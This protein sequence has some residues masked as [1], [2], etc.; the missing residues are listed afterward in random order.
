MSDDRDVHKKHRERLRTRFDR[1]GLEGF[2]DHEALELL[3]FYTNPQGDVNPV[4][5]RLMQRFGS[6]H[7]VLEATPEQLME[8][9]GVGG[10][11]ARLICLVAALHRRYCQDGIRYRATGHALDSTEKMAHFLAPALSA[12]QDENAVVACVDAK[13]RPICCEYVSKG[14]ARSSEILSRRIAEIAVRHSAP[15]VILAHNHPRGCAEPST[16]DFETT[17]RLRAL[18]QGLDI[19]LVDHIVIGDGE[20]VSLR[21]YGAFDAAL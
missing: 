1:E 10:Q 14:T 19:E 8:V 2:Q 17:Q 12:R 6:F 4:A 21:D 3:L 11:T 13:L 18:L 9:K 16:E 7:R 5:H 15:A 20:Y